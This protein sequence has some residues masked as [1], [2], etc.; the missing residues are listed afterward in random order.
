MSDNEE[1]LD[2]DYSKII[3]YHNV[4]KRPVLVMT[5]GLPR[6]GKST[7]CKNMIEYGAVIVNPDSIRLAIHGQPFIQEAEPTVWATAKYMV[8]SLFIAGHNIVILDATSINDK[9]R[10][11]WKSYDWETVYKVF[12]TSKET[13]LQRAIDNGQEYLLPVIERMSKNISYP[14]NNVL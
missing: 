2:K 8:K 9:S 11:E 13:C 7:W 12:H 10:N 14:E 6:S 5:V 3:G 4:S 1:M